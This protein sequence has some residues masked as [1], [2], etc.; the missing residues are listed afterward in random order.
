MAASLGAAKARDVSETHIPAPTT[1]LFTG[2]TFGALGLE[3]GILDHLGSF[4]IKTPTGI[5]SRGVPPILGG[6]DVILGAATG[7]GKTFAYLLPV[8]Q[9]L[10]QAEQFRGEEDAPL[11]V[12]RRPRALVLVPTRELAEQ[13]EQVARALSHVV[14]FRVIGA[15]AGGPGSMRKLKERLNYPVDVLV[16]TTGRLLQLLEERLIDVRFVKHVVI[17][18]VDTLCDKGFD[19]ELNKIL[20]WCKGANSNIVNHPQFIAAGATHPRAAE[21]I[22]SQV[23]PNAKRINVDL[24][25]A[26]R[27]LE[28]R[29]VYVGANTKVQE[30]IS[31]LNATERDGALTGGRMMVFCNT[32]DSCRFVDHFLV[33]SGYN[34]SCI[35]G[36]VPLERREKE[37]ESFRNGQKPLLI[38]TDMAARGLDNLKVDHVVLFDFPN[39][40]VD[41]LHRA[42]RT[43]RAGATGRVTSFVLKKDMRLA[44]AIQR[45][46]LHGYDALESARVSREQEAARKQRE[47]EA[48]AEREQMEV[49][50]EKGEPR[51][52][53]K[54]RHSV[55]VKR[56]QFRRGGSRVRGRGGSAGRRRAGR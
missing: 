52:M 46:G 38:C 28:Q 36:D 20:W 18:E 16:A 24:H 6:A 30:L 42:G 21:Q 35:H 9:Q 27:G 39:S 50:E 4:N 53:G 44:R 7:S 19:T 23:F 48:A 25:R 43:A 2:S 37:Y 31:F 56:L 8:V 40:A 34:T 15:L 47:K 49:V 1:P 13:V 32:M 33:E 26:P 5:Q 29:F 11:R 12:A 22:Y 3:E 55:G 51:R 45:A 54:G 41:Y 17:D 10:K 14:K